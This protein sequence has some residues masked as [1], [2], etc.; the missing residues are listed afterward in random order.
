VTKVEEP[1]DAAL[2]A[3]CEREHPR[4]VGALSLYTANPP[5]AEEL[6]QETLIRVMDAWP[7]VREMAAP[8]AYAHRIG[9]NLANSWFRRKAAERRAMRRLETV[10]Q[11]DDDIDLARILS[12]RA[13]VADLPERQRRC[14]LLRHHLG[15]PLEVTAATLGISEQAVSSLCYRAME[16]LRS[17]LR[18][19]TPMQESPDGR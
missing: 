16:N 17:Q 18:E 8:G 10:Q 9:M 11:R 14:L 1:E 4:L 2:V 6:A 5:L 12:V 7:R 15:Y 19:R 13:A 3:F